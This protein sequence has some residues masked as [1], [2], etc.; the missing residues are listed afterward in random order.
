MSDTN[1][2]IVTADQRLWRVG[3][4]PEPWAWSDWKYATEGGRFNGRW[5][6]IHGQFRTVYAGDSLFACLIEVLAKYRVDAPLAAALDQIFEDPADTEEYP[7]RP[8]AFVSYRWLE[9]RCASSATVH[10]SFCVV[11]ATGTIA[12]LRPR[13]AQLAHQLGVTDFDAAALKDSS[14]RDLTRSVASW[15]YQLTDPT[16]DGIQFR[17]RHGDDLPLWAIFERPST[18]ADVSPLLADIVSASLTPETAELM[19]AFAILGL[20]W[21]D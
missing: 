4:R 5:D 20:G 2:V 7:A 1:L 14:P 8:P 18:D 12:A 15:L 19:E 13:F 9:D 16:V 21:S 6:D 11:T 17:S 10:G 3:F